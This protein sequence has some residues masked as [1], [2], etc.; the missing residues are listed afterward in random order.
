MREGAG[1]LVYFTVYENY[2]RSRLK[3]GQFSHTVSKT[4][5]ILVAGSLAGISYWMLIYPVDAIKTQ[6][7]SGMCKSYL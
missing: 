5:D 2:I 3:E 1:A 7:Q 4:Q 6:V